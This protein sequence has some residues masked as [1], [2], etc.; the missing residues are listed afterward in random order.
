[1][2]ID[3]RH[4]LALLGGG[5][6]GAVFPI[7]AFSSA[8]V[9]KQKLYLSA[10]ADASGNYRAAGFLADG[11]CVFDLTLPGRGHGFAVSANNDAAVLFARR[12]GRFAL[13]LDLNRGCV[14][15]IIA[16]PANRHFYG[17]GAFSPDGRM[18]YATENDFEGERGVIGVYDALQGYGR[19]KEFP[20]Y[21]VGPHEVVLAPDGMTLA[22]AN[23]GIITRPDM[24]R[25]K[26]NLPTMSPSLCYIDRRDGRLRRKLALD[27][28]L[29]QLSIRHLSINSEGV[30]AVAMQYEGSAKDIVPLIALQRPNGR[31]ELIEGPQNVLQSMR[32]YCGSVCFDVSGETFAVSSPR[33]N[34]ITF[35][36]TDS[37]QHRSSV[38]VSDGCGVAPGTRPNEF[39]ASGGSGDL[40]TVDASVGTQIPLELSALGT[41]RWDNH[42]SVAFN[43]EKIQRFCRQGEKATAASVYGSSTV[44]RG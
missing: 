37:G 17:H 13:A 41:A 19:V 22:V 11:A 20:S 7:S 36:D 26:L 29:H 44:S 1:M 28:V 10:G 30:A 31:L 24:P 8:V 38:T 27:P 42:M 16:P 4:A 12:P 2:E 40:V 14:D 6:A 39:L 3:R 23:G 33:G 34:V 9:R 15:R 43:S 25:I 5:I 32:N 35:W 18:L 21:G